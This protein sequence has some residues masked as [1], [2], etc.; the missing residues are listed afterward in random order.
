[1]PNTAQIVIVLLRQCDDQLKIGFLWM[2]F[3][4]LSLEIDCVLGCKC[5]LRRVGPPPM[6]LK[7]RGMGS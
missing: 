1:M 5:K 4:I 6:N 2:G 3:H 7:V